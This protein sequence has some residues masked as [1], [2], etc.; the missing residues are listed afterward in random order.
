M[1]LMWLVAPAMILAVV[2]SVSKAPIS[3]L[4]TDLRYAI[5]MRV[6]CLWLVYIQ[7]A[8]SEMHGDNLEL[9]YEIGQ[10]SIRCFELEDPTHQSSHQEG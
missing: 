5:R 1:T 3:W 8:V 10:A 9:L 7:L 2:K 4:S 6:I